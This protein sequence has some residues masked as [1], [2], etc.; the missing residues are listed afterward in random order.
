MKK[1]IAATLALGMMTSVAS[2]ASIGSGNGNGNGNIGIGNGN[3]NG[4]GKG[5]VGKFFHDSS[6]MLR[7]KIAKEASVSLGKA[8]IASMA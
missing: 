8:C 7:I 2:A 3:A 4:N 6:F 5:N 1:L